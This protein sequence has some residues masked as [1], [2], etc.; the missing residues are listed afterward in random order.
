MREVFRRFAHKTGEIIGSPIAFSVAVFVVIGWAFAGPFFGFTTTWQLFI[1]TITTI[2]TFLTVF[3]IQNTQNRDSKAVHLKL[4][5]L[6]RTQIHASNDFVAVESMS[7]AE[8]DERLR[9]FEA[10]KSHYT[11]ALEKRRAKRQNSK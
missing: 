4:D 6:I 8:L 10:L 1:N 7:D 5:E 9:K 3:L 11:T 2:L